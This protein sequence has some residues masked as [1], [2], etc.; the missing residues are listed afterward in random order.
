MV[1]SF[2][3]ISPKL[4]SY[5]VL[6]CGCVCDSARLTFSQ[7][8]EQIDDAFF[9]KFFVSFLRFFGVFFRSNNVNASF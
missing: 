1:P 8:T 2:A 5:K 3:D 9:A 7:T 4:H 6:R